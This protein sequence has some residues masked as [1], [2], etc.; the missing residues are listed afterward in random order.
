MLNLKLSLAQHESDQ[1][2]DRVRYIFEGR[3]RIGKVTS[4]AIPDGYLIN[5]DKR[6]Q[7][8]KDVAPMVRAMFRH[9]IASRSIL[10][11]YRMLR[12][13]YDYKKS[14][15]AVG[16][17][18]RNRLYIGEYHGIKGFCPA[19]ISKNTFAQAQ[20]ILAGH[21]KRPRSSNI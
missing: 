7:I 11:T 14:D 18:L 4:G 6:I 8:D 12:E 13:K 21:A 17:A 5:D 20:A 10:R 19:L 3:R 15:S 16:R 1:T 2:G 9:F